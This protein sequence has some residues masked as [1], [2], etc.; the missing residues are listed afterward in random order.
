MLVFTCFR[1]QKTHGG[2]INSSTS[3]L[4]FTESEVKDGTARLAGVAVIDRWKSMIMA[5]V[6]L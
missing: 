3:H 5:E 4:H 2:I 1:T 6:M